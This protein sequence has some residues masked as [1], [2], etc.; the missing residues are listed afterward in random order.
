MIGWIRKVPF[1]LGIASVVFCLLTR[2]EAAA[3]AI[4][5]FFNTFESITRSF[6]HLAGWPAVGLFAH[7]PE[8]NTQRY[9]LVKEDEWV[10]DGV[11]KH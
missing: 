6:P 7:L 1:V 5:T 3:K 8:P 2:L 10:I 11:R 4:G 9:L